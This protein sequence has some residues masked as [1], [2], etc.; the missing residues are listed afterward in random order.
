MLNARTVLERDGLAVS[1]VRCTHA[2][3]SASETE[4]ANGYAVVFVRRGCFVRNVEGTEQVLDPTLAYCMN[5]EDEQHFDHPHGH[6]DDCTAL[7]LSAD[8]AASLSGGDPTLP[9]GTIPTAPQIDLRHRL[10]LSAAE[11]P[12]DQHALY[13]AAVMLV[14]VMLEGAAPRRVSAGR[15]TS[16]QARRALAD[17]VREALTADPDRSLPDLAQALST[18]PHHLSRVFAQVTGHTVSRHR[19]RLRTRSALERLATGDEDLARVAAD[20]GFADQS[21]FCRVVRDETGHTPSALRGALS[22]EPRDFAL[23]V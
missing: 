17:G 2:Q 8:L 7:T 10:L 20:A 19:M 13:E 23:P 12:H 21:H 1:D 11:R 4:L 6:G 22:R 9:S 5:P 18:S 3:G 15:R 14:A 16:A